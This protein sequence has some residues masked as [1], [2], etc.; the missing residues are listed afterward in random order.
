MRNFNRNI[1]M[2]LLAIWLILWGL[3]ALIPALSGLGIVLAILAVAAGVFIL[4]NR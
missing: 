2:L 1:G 3:T 4:I